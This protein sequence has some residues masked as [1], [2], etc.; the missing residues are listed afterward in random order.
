MGDGER[1]LRSRCASASGGETVQDGNSKHT[2]R[3]E[4]CGKIVGSRGEEGKK[5]GGCCEEGGGGQGGW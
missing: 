3:E 1:E 4:Q 5:T 2:E